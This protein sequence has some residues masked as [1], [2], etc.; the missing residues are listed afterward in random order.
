[1]YARVVKGTVKPGQIDEFLHTFQDEVAPELK[2][3]PGFEQSM[4]LTDRAN[5]AI[6]VVSLFASKAD[7]DASEPGFRKRVA[8]VMHHMAAPPEATIFEVALRV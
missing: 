5:D 4:V 1:M 7:M 2:A 3:E 6:T 8:E